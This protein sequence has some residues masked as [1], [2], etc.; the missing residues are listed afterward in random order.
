MNDL[1]NKVIQ[2]LI[3]YGNNVNDVNEMVNLHFETASK[4]YTKVSE[5]CYFIRVVY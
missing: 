3:A 2:K 4:K 1:K 5:I